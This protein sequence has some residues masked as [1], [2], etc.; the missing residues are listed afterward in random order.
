MKMYKISVPVINNRVDRESGGKELVL[1]ELLRIGAERVFLAVGTLIADEDERKK[2]FE[3]LKDNCAF[4]KSHGLEVGAW[5]WSFWSD[6]DM[7]F[8]HITGADGVVTGMNCPSDEN[9]ISFMQGYVKDIAKC[10]VDLI[11][12]DDDFRFG[13]QTGDIACMCENHMKRVREILS[14]N[15]TPRELR[16]KALTGGGSRCR[17][18]W[19]RANGESLIAFARAM[20]EAADSVDPTVRMGQCSCMSS[21]GVDGAPP[22]E[23]ARAFAGKTRPFFRL[24]G[25]PYWAVDRNFNNS[26]LQNVI[27]F[28]RMQRSFCTSEPEIFAEGDTYPRPRHWCPSSYLELFDIAMRADGNADGILKYAIDYWSRADY[29]T[30]YIDHHVKNAEAY[31]WTEK[32][33]SA[34]PA[35]GVR[36]YESLDKLKTMV[37]PDKAKMGAAV[38]EVMFSPAAKML[39]DCSVPTVYSGGGV[40]TAAFDENIR[41]VPEEALKNGVMIDM[42]AADI[43]AERGVD[44][45]ITE[46]GGKVH[47]ECEHFESGETVN[48]PGGVEA[49]KIRLNERCTV[50][51][52]FALGNEGQIPAVYIYKND[53]GQTFTVFNFDAYF[54]NDAAYRSYARSGQI[55][56]AVKL[57]T[58]KSLPAYSYGNPDFYI[59]AKRD[60]KGLTVCLFNIFADAAE[61]PVIELD[62]EYK[63]AEFFGC[64]G[65]ISGNRIF[66]S[67]IAPFAFAGLALKK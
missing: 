2:E 66:L 42:R 14:E 55:A 41:S 28:E 65:K 4:F 20:R 49:Y 22:E 13:H 51:S 35:V 54:G 58:G 56:R 1:S 23:I 62:E 8:T 50:L 48:I 67:D 37:L 39:A 5:L 15:I 7:G 29:E 44:V 63:E 19:M 6:R 45:G 57:M 11:M 32:N 47:A 52:R 36:V 61:N 10:G 40:C 59:M 24:I 27:E 60:S 31:E 16:E 9:F 25:A 3:I 38:Y 21:W 17:D 64:T 26:R 34:K 30:G 12:F 33:A 43:L 46:K 53:S 18:A